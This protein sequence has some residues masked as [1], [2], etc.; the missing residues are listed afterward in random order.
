M[1]KPARRYTREGLYEQVVEASKGAAQ[2]APLDASAP[3]APLVVL[4]ANAARGWTALFQN[5]Y[6]FAA[7]LLHERAAYRKGRLARAAGR[8]PGYQQWHPFVHN[9]SSIGRP[10]VRG[11]FF[12]PEFLVALP[13]DAFKDA[14]AMVHQHEIGEYTRF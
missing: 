13:E 11:A 7:S 4:A 1:L 2:E 3:T 5:P 12:V 9:R 8:G 10:P 6:F 14:I